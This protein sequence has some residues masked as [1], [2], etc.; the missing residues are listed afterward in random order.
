[1]LAIDKVMDYLGIVTSER[2][3]FQN[4]V[5]IIANKVL[6]TQHADAERRS[7]QK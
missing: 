7:R 2:L 3:E 5:Q 6:A 4:K 1:M